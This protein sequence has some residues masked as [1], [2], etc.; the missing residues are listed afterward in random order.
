MALACIDSRSTGTSPCGAAALVSVWRRW[1][2]GIGK[3]WLS[4]YFLFFSIRTPVLLY[5]HLAY[6][7]LWLFAPRNY[8]SLSYGTSPSPFFRNPRILV[9]RHPKGSITLT[10]RFWT[11]R[12][13]SHVRYLLLLWQVGKHTSTGMCVGDYSHLYFTTYIWFHRSGLSVCLSDCLSVTSLGFYSNLPVWLPFGFGINLHLLLDCRGYQ[14]R[15]LYLYQPI[16]VH[17]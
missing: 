8:W 11:C 15:A 6:S 10:G 9:M 16:I 4:L 2:M 13:N 12:S 1:T 7:L 17:R 5:S 3:A 14:L